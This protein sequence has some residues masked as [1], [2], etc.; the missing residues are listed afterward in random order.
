[1][2]TV[3]ACIEKFHNTVPVPVLDKILLCVG[4]GPV[5]YVTNPVDVEAAAQ[6]ARIDNKSV[7]KQKSAK[8]KN[9]PPIQMQQTN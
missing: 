5:V 4:A 7:G 9:D 1:M 3:S 8:K 6:S 2:A